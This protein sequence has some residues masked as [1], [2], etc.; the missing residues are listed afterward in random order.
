LVQF[1]WDFLDGT[2]G[3]GVT[4]S[5][6]FNS[7]GVFNVT[8]TVIDD[9]GQKAV[10]SHAVTVGRGDPIPVITPLSATVNQPVVFDSSATQVFGGQTIV[11]WTW[12]FQG[13]SPSSSTN[14]P[15]SVP[16]TFTTAGSHDV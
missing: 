15:Q 13:G 1:N 2:T 16:V 12:T 14:G 6:A 11:A 4:P 8:L 5:H 7:A 9:T 3:S 10:I